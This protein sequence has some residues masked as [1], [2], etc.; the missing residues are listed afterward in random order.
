MFKED[1]LTLHYYRLIGSGTSIKTFG[2]IWKL[3]L[4]TIL[5]RQSFQEL[6]YRHFYKFT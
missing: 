1:V 5:F 3:Y 4:K 2:F 6:Q